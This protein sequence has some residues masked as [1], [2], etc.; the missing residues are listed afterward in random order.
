MHTRRRFGAAVLG[1]AVLAAVGPARAGVIPISKA[2]AGP[3][4]IDFGPTPTGAP[5]DGQTING[6]TFH[7]TVAGL[8]SNNATIDAGPGNTNNITVAN[9]EGSPNASS[10]L[11]LSFPTPENRLGFGYAISTTVPVADATTVQLFDASNNLVG[12]LSAN[13]IP[14]PFFTGG[15]LGVESSIPFV[16]ADVTF[17]GANQAGAFAFDNVRFQPGLATVPEPGTLALLALGVAGL[18]GWRQWRR[19][20]T[21]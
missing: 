4:I 2:Q 9:I 18:A 13:G 7:F 8:P 5:I 1:L 17:S 15:F 11:S 6:V 3:V 21:A 14:D 20:A 12:T 16:R 19:R 10:V